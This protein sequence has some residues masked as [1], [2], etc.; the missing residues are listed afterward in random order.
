MPE[1]AA[2]GG[3]GSTGDGSIQ[4]AV[5]GG[6]ARTGS[7][8]VGDLD[9][10]LEGSLVIFDGRILEEQQRAQSA[11][12]GTDGDGPPGSEETGAGSGAVDVGGGA[13]AMPG[14]AGEEGGPD[15][16]VSVAEAGSVARP[17]PGGASESGQ[18]SG[19]PPEGI[20]DGD[21][22]DI[23]ARQLREAAENETDPALREKLWEEYRRYKEGTSR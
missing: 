13:P 7:E 3:T 21:D 18:A 17:M 11:R 23:V 9:G 6:S 22:D 16:D 19:A 4:V 12:R 10:E 1:G 20:P 5:I 15:G 2:G 14:S 8:Q